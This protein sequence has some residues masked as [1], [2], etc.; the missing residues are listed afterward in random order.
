MIARIA[1][2]ALLGLAP[3]AAIAQ[4]RLDQL[5]EQAFKA[6]VAKI[7]PAVVQIQTFGGL[8]RVGETLTGTG[9]TTGVIVSEDGEIISSAF[10]FAS[11]PAA[12]V[13][14]LPDGRQLDAT[15]VATDRSRM[16]TL[17]KVEA[18]GLPVPEPASVDDAK[19]GQWTLAVGKA[20]DP[21]TPNASAGV[22]S[23]KDRI[24]GKALQTDAKTSPL[25][26]GGPLIEIHGRMLG[27]IVPL[28]MTSDEVMAGTEWYDS[29]IGFAIPYPQ[30][31]ASV[32]RL[33][34][35]DDLHR[36]VLGVVT[37]EPGKMF[38]EPVVGQVRV[39]SPAAEAG[40]EKGD[41][42]VAVD[43]RRVT[44]Q[45]EVLQALGPKYAGDV[46]ELTVKRGDEERTFT[47][48]LEKPT[49]TSIA[50]EQEPAQQPGEDEPPSHGPSGEASTER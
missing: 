6:A 10:A 27:I 39:G 33:K 1:L 5:E 31:M 43:G 11:K 20:F 16:L 15:L 13:V 48:T 3:L 26:Y 25:N 41:V 49:R 21:A 44:R 36:G 38:A 24:W 8:D 22:L 42:I 35:G 9:P 7:A 28:S 47:I 34:Q 50:P 12:V 29:G 4:E 19:V 32:E 23:A 37:T 30:V 45:A 18:S 2:T 17:L 40:L 46:V 14:R